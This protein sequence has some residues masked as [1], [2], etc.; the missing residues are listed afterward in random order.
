MDTARRSERFMLKMRQHVDTDHGYSPQLP[1]VKHIFFLLS[2]LL[3]FRGSDS[4]LPW[5]YVLNA[6]KS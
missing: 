3:L 1:R 2:K 4:V 5:F 6:L